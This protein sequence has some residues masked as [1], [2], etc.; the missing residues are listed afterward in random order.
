MPSQTFQKRFQEKTKALRTGKASAEDALSLGHIVER[1]KPRFP[2][3]T[4]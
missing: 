3:G 1:I 4:R 2:P